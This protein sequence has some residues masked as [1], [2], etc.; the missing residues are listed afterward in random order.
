MNVLHR[1]EKLSWFAFEIFRL[2]TAGVAFASRHLGGAP[3]EEPFE[4][5]NGNIIARVSGGP[6]SET[7]PTS[8]KYCTE[9]FE[10]CIMPRGVCLSDG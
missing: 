9:G 2:A 8:R 7:P 10:G 3:I 5:L 6:P 4:N 1:F